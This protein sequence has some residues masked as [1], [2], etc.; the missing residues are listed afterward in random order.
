MDEGQIRSTVVA[1]L[2]AI[3]PELD[4]AALRHGD[5]LRNQVDLDSFDWLHF[6]IGLHEQFKVEIPEADYK[7]LATIDQLVAY[8]RAKVAA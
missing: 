7:K 5:S 8:I 4:A 3:A 2:Q 6:L 1:A